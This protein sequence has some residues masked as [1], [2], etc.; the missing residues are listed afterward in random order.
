MAEI[1]VNYRRTWQVKPYET[2]SIELGITDTSVPGTPILQQQANIYR[3][4]GE[5]ADSLMAERLS[6]HQ[7]PRED[8]GA[9]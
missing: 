2:E 3:Q 7:R 4:L 1:R 9:F 5:L 8:G 6:A